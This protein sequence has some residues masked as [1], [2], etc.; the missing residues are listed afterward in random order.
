MS[1]VFQLFCV[2]GCER[3]LGEVELQDGERFKGNTHYGL[4]CEFDIE[5]RR[6][7]ERI[8]ALA[9]RREAR[10]RELEEEEMG[11]E[12]YVLTDDNPNDAVPGVWKRIMNSIFKR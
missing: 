6:E 9:A 1:R 3:V 5:A 11:V 8:A 2:E 4:V 12:T 7:R 10:A